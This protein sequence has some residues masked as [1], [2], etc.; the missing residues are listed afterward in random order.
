VDVS[1][2]LAREGAASFAVAVVEE[3]V[4]LRNGGVSGEVLVMGWIGEDQLPDLLRHRLVA[5]AHSLPL[6]HALGRFARESGVSIPLHLKLDTGMTRLGLLPEE[7]GEAAEMLRSFSPHLIVTGVYQNFA[8]ADD[9]SSPQ[10]AAQVR[11]FGEILSGLRE[12][13][14]APGLVHVANSAGTLAPPAWPADL[15]APARVRPGLALYTRFPWHPERGP[16]LLDVMTFHSVVA[17]VKRVPEG[18]RVGYG[19]TFVAPKESVIALVPAG[20]ADGVPRSLS[21]AGHV[22]VSGRRCPIV[23]RVSMDVTA[24]DVTALSPAPQRGD[25]VVLFGSQAGERLGVEEMAAAAGT[26]SWEVLCG[27]GPRVPRVIV[28]RGAESRVTS[29]FL[30]ARRNEEE[31]A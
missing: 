30:I 28:E 14:I 1:L 27:V 25:E 8:S 17:Q 6:L 13:G 20:Y 7:V 10:T 2:R 23:G 11:V 29:R 22:L 24:V 3:G 5:N 26:V 18:T 19:G 12:R 21:N 31:V 4:E 9:A 15:P 16:E